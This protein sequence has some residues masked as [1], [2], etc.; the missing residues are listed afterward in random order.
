MAETRNWRGKS[1][2]AEKKEGGGPGGVYDFYNRR[3]V[4]AER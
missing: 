3:P 1:Y 2:E 4:D